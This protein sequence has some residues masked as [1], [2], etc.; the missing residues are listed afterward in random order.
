VHGGSERE[1]GFGV[2]SA[3]GLHACADAGRRGPGLVSHV[4][5]VGTASPAKSVSGG[6]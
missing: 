5:S 6:A 3:V 4:R 1:L 2:A